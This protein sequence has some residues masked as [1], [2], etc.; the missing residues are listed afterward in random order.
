[1][2]TGVVRADVTNNI[3]PVGIWI[4]ELTT[5]F[6]SSAIESTMAALLNDL[7]VLAQQGA[8]LDGNDLAAFTALLTQDYPFDYHVAPETPHDIGCAPAIDSAVCERVLDLQT[9]DC[10]TRIAADWLSESRAGKRPPIAR[11]Q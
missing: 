8:S 9:V 6:F 10:A 1:M 2:T 11:R 4:L 3:P 7:T 5:Q